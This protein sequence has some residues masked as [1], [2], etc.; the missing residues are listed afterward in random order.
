MRWRG[1]TRSAAYGVAEV[2][3]AHATATVGRQVGAMGTA[4]AG[5]RGR[6]GTR[7]RARTAP[8]AVP[9][10]AILRLSVSVA[11]QLKDDI[12]AAMKAGERERVGALRLLMSELQKAAKEGDGDEIAVLR[13]E[14][15]RRLDAAR[16]FHDGGREELARREEREAELIGAYLP[17]ELSDDELDGIVREAIAETGA[18]SPRDIGRVMKV[19]MARAGGRADGKRVSARVREALASS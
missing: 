13:R 5:P 19:A 12:T 17:A 3:G 16:Q 18:S 14:R 11:Q 15:K 7:R 2:M 1:T 8:A 6:A 10:A 4:G 9:R